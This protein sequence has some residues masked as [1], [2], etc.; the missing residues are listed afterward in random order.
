M[1]L[2]HHDARPDVS[3]IIPVF[4]KLE[5]TRAC[6]AS[7][8]EHGAQASFEIIVV[9]NGSTD[10]TREWLKEQAARGRLKGILN[11][12][13][14]G[15]SR[16][17][18]VGAEASSGRFILFLNNDMEV[19][20]NWLDPMVTIL[21]NDPAVGI[22]GAKLLFPDNTIQHAGVALVRYDDPKVEDLSGV[23]IA[24]QKPSNTPGA[25]QARYVQIVTGAALL[26]RQEIFFELAGFSTEFWNGNEDVDLCLRAGEA[27]WKVVYQ[28]ESMIIHYESQSGPERWTQVKENVRLFNRKWS[29]RAK[30]D[31]FEAAGQ[32]ELQHTADNQIRNY[33]ERRI[34]RDIHSSSDKDTVS[35]IVLTWNALEYTK[36]CA[37]SLLEHTD[38]RHELIFVDNGSEA[39]TR[40]FLSELAEKNSRVKVIFNGEN[41]GFAAGNN[42]GI[43]AATGRHVCL[44]NSDTVVTDGWLEN[45]LAHMTNDPRI[46]MVG[47]L[48]NSITGPQKLEKVDYDEDTC[49]GLAAF[50]EK[51]TSALAGNC[52]ESMWVVGF[53]VLIRDELIQRLGGLDETFGQGN[54]ED[55][56]YCLRAFVG[57]YASVIA[58]D[59]FV[60]H[61]GSRSFVS[62]K[63]DYA[64]ELRL[65]H[66]IFR[67]KWNLSSGDGS[68]ESLNL[69]AMT[70]LGFV[71]AL[72]FQALPDVPTIPLWDWE[73]DKWILQGEGFFVA[74]RFDEAVRVFRQV[75][76]FCPED[77]RAANNLA[78]TLW[79]IGDPT[80]GI[81]EALRILEGVLQRDP[82]NEDARWNLQEMRPAMVEN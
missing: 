82:G 30:A 55:T 77:N 79:R 5:L 31:L 42:I 35:V 21:D 81:P 53:A 70:F 12:E 63:V 60:H 45:M 40:K 73:K 32:K 17:C 65:K 68:D 51:T 3:V 7:I 29:G 62:G 39:D 9:D 26:I 22:A 20:P 6:I 14:L 72:H 69:G 74:E 2:C 47:P 49:E 11:E 57:G 28:P 16:G 19:T 59:S 58:A 44:L 41:L 4:N 13:N 50:A 8:H 66:E 46:G 15:F 78:C 64:N 61:F 33:T 1:P 25:N 37:A 18:N 38:T 80:D 23:H 43:A 56:D 75:L 27:G 10:G 52:Q 36:L 24:Y 67:K 54:Y 34:V 48:T 76:H 71:P